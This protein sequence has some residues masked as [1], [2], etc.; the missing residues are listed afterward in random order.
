MCGSCPVLLDRKV[1]S[2]D[3]GAL[4][5][6][7]NHMWPGFPRPP[8]PA[9]PSLDLPGRPQPTLTS[10]SRA[11]DLGGSGHEFPD[12]LCSCDKNL[13]SYLLFCFDFGVDEG[14]G[15][16]RLGQHRLLKLAELVLVIF[17]LGE[18]RPRTVPSAQPCQ[19]MPTA[20]RSP[21]AP[22]CV[23]LPTHPRS[24]HLGRMSHLG[25]S[26]EARVMSASNQSLA[27]PAPQAGESTCT[28]KVGGQDSKTRGAAAGPCPPLCCSP[29]TRPC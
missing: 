26:G 27:L 9:Y 10:R 12:S 14:N 28:A 3:P 13:P 15:V 5:S 29:E 20:S 19:V 17:S 11:Q 6:A 16:R 8:L 1:A 2:G 7:V 22:E 25:R 23:R 18:A 4:L 21:T 24:C